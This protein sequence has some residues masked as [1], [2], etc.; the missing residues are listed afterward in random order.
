MFERNTQISTK[1]EGDEAQLV[2]PLVTF[3][4]LKSP[5]ALE[6]F[7]Q[8]NVVGH[9]L[10]YLVKWTCEVQKMESLS[11]KIKTKFSRVCCLITIYQSNN[12][13]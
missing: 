6:Y 10:F 11:H 5:H 1:V 9:I 13:S 4:E 8:Q 12:T 2:V 7:F 3:V